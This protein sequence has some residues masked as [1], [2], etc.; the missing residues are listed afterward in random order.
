MTR[1]HARL[2]REKA[3]LWSAV[4]SAAIHG[5]GATMR[6]LVIIAAVGAILIMLAIVGAHNA[7][8]IVQKILGFFASK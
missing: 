3:T 4:Q 5:W 8:T 1:K 6:M 2:R 7:P